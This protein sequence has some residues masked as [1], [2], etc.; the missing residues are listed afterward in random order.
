M[1]D[2]HGDDLYS[3]SILNFEASQNG[4]ING[5][6]DK[7]WFK[8][9]LIEGREYYFEL[10]GGSL[11]TPSLQLTDKNGRRLVYDLVYNYHS[12]EDAWLEYTATYSGDYYLIAEDSYNGKNLSLIHI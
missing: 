5:W 7:D 4:K 12:Y 9:E 3:A 8:V 6:S 2:N 1:A 11:R 10:E